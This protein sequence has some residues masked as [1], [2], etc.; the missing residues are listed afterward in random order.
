MAPLVLL[1]LLLPQLLQ[2]LA[3]AV[4]T[5]AMTTTAP[6]Y[7]ADLKYIRDLFVQLGAQCICGIDLST[8]HTQ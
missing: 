4:M 5:V 7:F 3:A 2:S 1:L 8:F 6:G